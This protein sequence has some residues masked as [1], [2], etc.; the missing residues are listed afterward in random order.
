MF[1]IRLCRNDTK[2]PFCKKEHAKGQHFHHIHNK[3]EVLS[4][5]K[6]CPNTEFYLVRIFLY[7]D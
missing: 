4:L 6:K 3:V 2:P 5:R 7:L 1:L